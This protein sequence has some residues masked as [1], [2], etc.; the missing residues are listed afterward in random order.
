V[1][2]GSTD[3]PPFPNIAARIEKIEQDLHSWSAKSVDF[4]F[5][6][7]GTNLFSLMELTFSYA[8]RC[9]AFASSI[10]LLLKDNHI[11]P[12]TVIARA[13]IETIGIGC[14]FLSD[15]DRLIA[16]G[17]RD[18]LD[19]RLKRFYAGIKGSG[20]EPVHVLDG[21]RHL[22]QLDKAYV[23]Y[24]DEKYGVFT[25]LI[26]IAKKVKPDSPDVYEV[27]SVIKN[28]NDLSEV[29]H[30]NGVGTQ[31]MYP[32]S[33]N[34][35]ATAEKARD[36]FRTASVLA[37]LQARYLITALEQGADLPDRYRTAFMPA[38]GGPISTRASEPL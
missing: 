12:A 15:M 32:D 9:A 23:T 31:F 36:R 2:E 27:L 21:I 7:S 33:T 22:E 8:K 5:N 38:P 10:R 14:L 37:I 11:V 3:E 17:D 4:S 28:Y 20:V 13:L 35:N 19:A 25:H 30:P 18:R 34:E 1:R 6:P 16:A 29:A 24:L 26:G